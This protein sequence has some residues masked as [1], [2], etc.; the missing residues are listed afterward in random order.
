MTATPIP[1][2]LEIALV[3]IAEISV[4]VTPPARRQPVRTVVQPF[5][6]VSLREALLWENRRGGQ[7]FVV[8]PR[9]EEI[10]RLAQRL[11]E[12]VP[13]LDIAIA[14]AK[15]PPA[16]LDRIMVEF[17]DGA[18]DVLLSTS[19]I[20][21]G[22]DLP[23]ANTMIVFRPDRFG[24]AQ[25]HQLRGRVGRGRARASCY[26]LLDPEAPPTRAAEKRLQTLR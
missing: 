25:L 21:S 14:H 10:D 11:A 23:A 26:L 2:T 15:L 17:A 5:D 9:I 18:G 24:L 12:F 8:T 7:T 13:E 19:I 6:P 22:L 20:E 4:I 1:R 16:E 3:D